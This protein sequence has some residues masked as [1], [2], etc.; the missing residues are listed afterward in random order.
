MDTLRLIGA[1]AMTIA[2]GGAGGAVAAALQLPAGWLIGSML[3]SVVLVMSGVRLYMPDWVRQIIFVLLG[4]SMGSGFTQESI[5]TML[6]WPL[7]LVGLAVAV[8]G[9]MAACTAFLHFAAR[10]DKATS[11]FSSVPGAMSYVLAM[12][13]RT[14]A[15]T[16]L[17]VIAQ[18]SRLLVLMAVLPLIVRATMPMDAAIPAMP[19]DELRVI[20]TLAIEIALGFALGFLLEWLKVPAG[21]MV[22]GMI[23]GAGVHLSGTLSG[24]MPQPILVPC[25]ILLGAFIGLRFAGTDIKLLRE[26]A[27]PSFTSFLIAI[28]IS[29]GIALA[30]A[31]GLDLPVGQVLVAF[32]PG[33]LE[34][35][36]I[37]A[38]VLGV[39]PAYVGVHQLARFLGVSLLLPFIARFYL[40]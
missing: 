13:L 7:S 39:D 4:V 14:T 30:V 37:L 3:V 34:A 1:A 19:T 36:T 18:M 29:G 32:A 10:W 23:A 26:A 40:K 9:M 2:V 28:A 31:Y 20:V 11:F 33:G 5:N 17:V 38:F 21:L 12:S 35:M 27:L 15:D 22:G 16:R 8:I 25:Q 24:A 6:K